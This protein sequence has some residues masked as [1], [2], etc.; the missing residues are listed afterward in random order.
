[1]EVKILTTH[2]GLFVDTNRLNNGIY[3]SQ[4]PT[5]Y[6]TDETIDNIVSRLEGEWPFLLKNYV[7]NI[8]R[9]KLTRYEIKPI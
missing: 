8:K 7:K 4:K 1:M 3:T 9:C 5:I 2:N 6:A